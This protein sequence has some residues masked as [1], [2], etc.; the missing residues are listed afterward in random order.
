MS[1]G[2][3]R[4]PLSPLLSSPRS[5]SSL[6]LSHLLLLLLVARR[7]VFVPRRVLDGGAHEGGRAEGGVRAL[8][9]AV[10]LKVL[11]R[12]G[13]SGRENREV[14]GGGKG[15]PPLAPP[16]LSF[17]SHPTPP[18]HTQTARPH[19]VVLLILREVVLL[20]LLPLVLAV[21]RGAVLVVVVVVVALVVVVL[22][23]LLDFVFAVVLLAVVVVVLAGRAGAGAG[24]AL[25]GVVTTVILA[26]VVTT[27][28]LAGVVLAAVVVLC[29]GVS[30]GGVRQ[31]V[32]ACTGRKGASAPPPTPHRRA[33][34]RCLAVR[35]CRGDVQQ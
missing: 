8:L 11:E 13:E 6:S 18:P 16:L 31:R 28:I 5:L 27:V 34:P 23:L 17:L 3:P 9:V 35:R 21:V 10:V 24:R 30:G 20:V 29:E 25:A 33:A 15:P 19:L 4:K 1:A 26:G 32:W 12:E 7:K 22:L 14:R 2:G